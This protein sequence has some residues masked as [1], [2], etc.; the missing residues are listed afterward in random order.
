MAVTTYN[1]G[2]NPVRMPAGYDILSRLVFDWPGSSYPSL[3]DVLVL[4]RPF[5]ATDWGTPSNAGTGYETRPLLAVDG[6]RAYCAGVRTGYPTI[7]NTFQS[8]S[9][10]LG[11]TWTN[12]TANPA[13]TE[14]DV[15]QTP[16]ACAVVSAVGEYHNA[17]RQADRWGVAVG[18]EGSGVSWRMPQPPIWTGTGSD[19]IQETVSSGREDPVVHPLPDGR[20]EC[21]AVT[22]DTL[23]VWR[24]TDLLG[25]AWEVHREDTLDPALQTGTTGVV[26]LGFWQGRS[27][28]QVVCGEN[29]SPG[30]P[31]H[32]YLWY[33]DDPDG[34]FTQV[35]MGVALAG[36]M[37]PY[38]FERIAGGW[39]FGYFD[40]AFAWQQMEADH[41]GASWSGI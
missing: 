9:D 29:T 12:Y 24:S 32:H 26:H 18:S 34:A 38:C 2:V 27:G 28:T 14:H 16:V 35:D 3:G 40:D 37:A 25:M 5:G 20:W 36:H 21:I 19:Y 31:W 33:R 4:F 15:D 30:G 8:W 1:R 39:E 17:I 13:V 41:P 11:V 22:D 10:D 23:W 6:P 7:T